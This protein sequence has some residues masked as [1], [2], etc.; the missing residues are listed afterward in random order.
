MVS[1]RRLGAAESKDRERLNYAI[2]NQQ[3]QSFLEPGFSEYREKNA[4]H[5]FSR[6]QRDILVPATEHSDLSIQCEHVP[7]PSAADKMKFLSAEIFCQEIFWLPWLLTELMDFEVA[8]RRQHSL[9]PAPTGLPHH[10]AFSA[11]ILSPLLPQPLLSL[12]CLT[13]AAR[14]FLESVQS[15]EVVHP[16]LWHQVLS[17]IFNLCKTISHAFL[18]IS[19]NSSSDTGCGLALHS[20]RR[21]PK[22]QIR[23]KRGAMI[24]TK[25]T[26]YNSAVHWLPTKCTL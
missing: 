18:G 5:Y 23:I 1:C 6:H 21:H 8:Q 19:L 13:W 25:F 26:R 17:H 15:L 3:P 20:F 2:C 16:F 14:L 9:L 22:F 4:G 7:Q 12:T 10:W 11:L 24:L